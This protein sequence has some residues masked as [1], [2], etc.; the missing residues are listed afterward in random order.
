MLH[1][2]Q[3]KPLDAETT[4][5]SQ[6]LDELEDILPHI[7]SFE[8]EDDLQ[9]A[10]VTDLLATYWNVVHQ[11]LEAYDS[12]SRYRLIRSLREMY[13]RCCDSNVSTAC[14]IYIVACHIES[15]DLGDRDGRLVHNLTTLHIH[16]A[17]GL[18]S[19]KT[20]EA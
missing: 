15:L 18:L 16:R 11:S 19:A 12:R 6:L 9:C 3:H 5:G 8:D 14:G 4:R 17:K 7:G 10:I 20:I 1:N 13:N 2:R